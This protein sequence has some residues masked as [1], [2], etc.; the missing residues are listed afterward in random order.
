MGSTS[1]PLVDIFPNSYHLSAWYFNENVRRNSVLVTHGSSRIK[2]YLGS[3]LK[4]V[5]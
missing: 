3:T 1:N 2:E 4:L 5:W